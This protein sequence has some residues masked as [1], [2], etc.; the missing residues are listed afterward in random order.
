MLSPVYYLSIESTP[1]QKGL[2]VAQNGYNATSASVSKRVFV[3]NHSY[4]NVSPPHRFIFVQMKLIFHKR[5]YTRTRLEIK[6]QGS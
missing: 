2:K 3:R 6:V 1:A 4:E 5:F